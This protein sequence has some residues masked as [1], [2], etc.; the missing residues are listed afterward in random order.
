MTFFKRKKSKSKFK[1]NWS[2]KADRFTCKL[3]EDECTRNACLCDE[4]L[5]FQLSEAE[6]LFDPTTSIENGFTFDTGSK[7]A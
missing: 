7:I 2:K 4:K 5:A 6:D 3:I 1:V